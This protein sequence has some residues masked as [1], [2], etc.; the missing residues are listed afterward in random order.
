MVSSNETSFPAFKFNCSA[1]RSLEHLTSKAQQVDTIL[2]GFA[3]GKLLQICLDLA[4]MA[5]IESG[6][7]APFL[8]FSAYAAGRLGLVG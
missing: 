7:Q 6:D 2:I 1:G 8:D 4:H 5:E 3:N